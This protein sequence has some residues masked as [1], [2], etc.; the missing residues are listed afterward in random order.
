MLIRLG[1]LIKPK[2]AVHIICAEFSIRMDTMMDGVLISIPARDK[3]KVKTSQR[4][5]AR[6]VLEYFN[7]PCR[8]LEI[9][10][11]VTYRTDTE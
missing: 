8:R 7:V 11:I 9:L 4:S 3:A 5:H 1:R 10:H 6:L 2:G